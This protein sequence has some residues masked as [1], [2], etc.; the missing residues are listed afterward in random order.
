MKEGGRLLR[1]IPNVSPLCCHTTEARASHLPPLRSGRAFSCEAKGIISS[2]A[3]SSSS[4]SLLPLPLSFSTRTR[5]EPER[6]EGR[7]AAAVCRS[8]PE[9]VCRRRFN[10]K[11]RAALEGR[12]LHA[13]QVH[14]HPCLASN[15]STPDDPEWR[16]PSLISHNTET[17]EPFVLFAI[18]FRRQ[19][20]RRQAGRREEGAAQ[21]VMANWV[22]CG[23]RKSSSKH[24]SHSC[25]DGPAAP[26]LPPPRLTTQMRER[27]E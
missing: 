5:T 8:E 9:L 24:S 3:P 1:I 15:S 7:A 23:L 20:G 17:G 2:V 25:R 14:V 22:C 12:I 26:P 6:T 4:S 11:S 19:A 16:S 21:S 18:E 27:E 10:A 13:W